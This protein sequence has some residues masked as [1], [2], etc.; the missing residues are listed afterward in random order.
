MQDATSDEIDLFEIIE[1]IWDGKWLITAITGGLCDFI[2][3]VY[4]KFRLALRV[5][6]DYGV[7]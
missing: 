2:S 1:I 3:R 7:E 4:F 6:I 5:A